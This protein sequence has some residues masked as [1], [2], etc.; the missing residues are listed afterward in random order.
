M[1]IV[2]GMII[3]LDYYSLK[4]V[5]NS[6]WQ[7]VNLDIVLPKGSPGKWGFRQCKRL[8][9]REFQNYSL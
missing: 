7:L 4:P 9:E 5:G 8:I 1:D 6:E 3:P 2:V